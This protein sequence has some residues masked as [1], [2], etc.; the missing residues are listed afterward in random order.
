MEAVRGVR[1]FDLPRRAQAPQGEAGDE[2]RH[3]RV[4]VDDVVALLR[5]QFPHKIRRAREITRIERVAPPVDG[6]KTI[7]MPRRGGKRIAHVGHRVDLPA[8]GA[9]RVAVRKQ[10]IAQR[11]LDCRYNKKFFH[12]KF[13][14]AFS[15]STRD[16]SNGTILYS[17]HRLNSR[18]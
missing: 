8:L 2:R 9:E 14:N 12:C 1:D 16:C 15:V 13:S 3:G 11:S 4:H 6:V 10:K 5:H 7:E 18:A 17:S